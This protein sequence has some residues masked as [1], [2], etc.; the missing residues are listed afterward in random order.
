MKMNPI[1]EALNA[2]PGHWQKGSL[3]DNKGNHCGLGHMHNALGGSDGY[4]PMVFDD[5]APE[6]KLSRDLRIE[7]ERLR[8]IMDE[9]A[10]EQYPDRV[11]LS[12]LAYSSKFAEFN[13]H[14]DTTEDEVVAVMEK[15]AIR[16]DEI[17]G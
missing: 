14:P 6:Y 8:G 7:A 12:P 4:L 2:L 5:S 16:L 9:V 11:G 3:N 17:D 1:R 10:V 13:D 15:A